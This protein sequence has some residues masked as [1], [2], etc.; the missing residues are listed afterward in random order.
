MGGAA[1]DI[2]SNIENITGGA[3]ND[4]LTG[5]AAGN[6]LLGGAGNDLLAGLAGSDTLDGGAGADTASYADKTLAVS[7][8]L[9]GAA[10]VLVRIGG[11]V[12]DTI[13]NIE[14]ITGGSG[15][16]IVTG[17]TL[18]N[19]LS[20]GAG[21]DTLAGGGG[22]D[23]LSGGAEVDRFLFSAAALGAAAAQTVTVTDF[24][25]AAGERLDLAGIDANTLLAGTNPFAFIGTAAF[26]NVAGQLR[27]TDLVTQTRIE[28]DVNG[29]GSADL[30]SVLGGVTGG[31]AADWFKLS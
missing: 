1:N 7:V 15:D 26:G 21:S 23:T 5:D 31:I 6:A 19:V 8:T 2:V 24:D 28:G 27:Y 11:L 12:E 16:D 13:R 14:N 17:D 30:T 18:A 9:N 22:G 20:G 3:G 29:D 10:A 25:R 4:V